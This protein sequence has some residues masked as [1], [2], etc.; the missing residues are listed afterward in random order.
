MIISYTFLLSATPLYTI[1]N[2]NQWRDEL[3]IFKKKFQEYFK[4]NL[5]L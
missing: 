1:D 3:T 5:K 2:Y 4:K